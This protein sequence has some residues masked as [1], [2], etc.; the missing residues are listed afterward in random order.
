MVS[1]LWFIP[2]VVAAA[3]VWPLMAA[4]RRLA[5][6]LDALRESIRALADLDQQVVAVGDEVRRSYR[7]IKNLPLR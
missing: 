6:D 3:A 5:A 1:A 2:L 7:A 4:S